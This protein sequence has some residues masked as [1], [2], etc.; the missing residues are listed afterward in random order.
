[1]KKLREVLNATRSK[2]RERAFGPLALAQLNDKCGINAKR[3][4]HI[5][6]NHD[7]EFFIAPV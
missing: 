7:F 4:N 1:M 6:F 3:S 2:Q 5:K